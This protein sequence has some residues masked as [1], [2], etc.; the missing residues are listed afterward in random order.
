MDLLDLLSGQ[1]L[2]KV[3]FSELTG[4]LRACLFGVTWGC[5]FHGRY[6]FLC[7]MDFIL[8]TLFCSSVTHTSEELRYL[9]MRIAGKIRPPLESDLPVKCRH[10]PS[11]QAGD[12][13]ASGDSYPSWVGGAASQT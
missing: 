12:Y 4:M 11:R 3:L 9:K 10:G 13:R 2:T 7:T 6:L 5:F 8:N 1:H